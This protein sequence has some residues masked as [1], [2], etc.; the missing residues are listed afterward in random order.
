MIAD[1]QYDPEA[2]AFGSWEV[3]VAAL[4][5]RHVRTNTSSKKKMATP[6]A[7]ERGRRHSVGNGRPVRLVT[8]HKRRP[9]RKPY[10]GERMSQ[11]DWSDVQAVQISIDRAAFQRREAAAQAQ[12]DDVGDRFAGVV[13]ATGTNGSQTV[14]GTTIGSHNLTGKW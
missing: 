1:D 4:R 14:T 3:A 10:H 5:E 6:A 13:T 9:N 8:R 7:Q 12:A 11:S 2:D